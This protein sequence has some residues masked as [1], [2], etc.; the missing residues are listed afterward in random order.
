MVPVSLLV[1]VDKRHLVGVE[2]PCCSSTCT[3]KEVQYSINVLAMEEV[4][5]VSRKLI[6][7]HS[8]IDL[9]GSTGDTQ[10]GK[11]SY[12]TSLLNPK[13][14]PP[15]S[16]KKKKKCSRTS[17]LWHHPWPQPWNNFANIGCVSKN[18]QSSLCLF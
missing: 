6:K 18:V 4:F 8:H 5:L 1:Y 11:C 10:L 2:V 9:L 7:L 15:S 17:F 16:Y 12:T 13:L 3:I 14:L